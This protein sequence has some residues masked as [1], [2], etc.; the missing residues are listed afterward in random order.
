MIPARFE[1]VLWTA[2]SGR[3]GKWRVRHDPR[4][5]RPAELRAL[6]YRKVVYVPVREA[7][8][9]HVIDYVGSAVRA[10]PGAAWQRVVGEHQRQYLD[11]R[12]DWARVAVIGLRD[13]APLLAVRWIEAA[14]AEQA[15]RPPKCVRLPVLPAGWRQLLADM[16]A[17][18]TLD[19]AA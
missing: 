7:R 2:M 8:D 16:P 4:L 11:R 12:I 5:L 1:T 15:G 9:G 10:R 18:Q 19:E 3:A 13:D 17:D 14:V 6:P